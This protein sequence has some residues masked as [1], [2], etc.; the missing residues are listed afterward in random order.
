VITLVIDGAGA[1][2]DVEVGTVVY[3]GG[4]RYSVSVL[5]L[6]TLVL[7]G[8][9]VQVAHRKVV[10]ADGAALA[11]YS[12]RPAGLEGADAKRP[13][14]IISDVGFGRALVTPLAE[15]LA[16][17][18]RRVFVAELRGQGA[19]EPAHSLRTTF[20]LDFPAIAWAIRL[21]TRG[22]PVDLIAHGY[23]GTLAL[24]A[25]THG[26]SVERAV[27]LNTPAL[28]EPP[29]VLLADFLAHGGRFSTLASSPEG[30]GAFVALFAMGSRAQRRELAA[31]A[32]AAR[33]LGPGVS[34]ELLAWMQTGDLPLDDGTSVKG[35]LARYDRPTLL[36]LGLADAFAPAEACAPLRELAKGPVKVRL[37]SRV[38][39]GDDYAHASLFTGERAARQIFPEIE[40]FLR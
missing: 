7:A 11:L 4:T 8:C 29:T 28:A 20:T 40:E 17:S 36:L 35:R 27:A 32:G 14:L 38:V 19:A 9:D 39:Q 1:D 6:I 16:R 34:R 30:F 25:T 26:L 22:Q 15:H 23:L 2:A 10:T 5:A 31:A 33:D 3:T 21:E 12:F 37:F 24:A 13:V 18:G